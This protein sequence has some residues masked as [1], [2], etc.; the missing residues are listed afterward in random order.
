V[1]LH[2]LLRALSKV[3]LGWRERSKEGGRRKLPFEMPSS[4]EAVLNQN[5]DVPFD[6]RDPLFPF[7]HGLSYE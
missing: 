3:G 5:E 4:W 2:N 7:G 6:S 1:L